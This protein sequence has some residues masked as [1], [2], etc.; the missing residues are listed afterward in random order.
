M[1]AFALCLHVLAAA[2]W[3]GGQLLLA[4]VV[5]PRAWRQGAPELVLTHEHGLGRIALGALAV[6]VAS[7]LWMAHV[8]VPEVTRWWRLDGPM[9]TAVAWKIG[10]LVLS[11]ALAL[12]TR[13][14]LLPRL[15][16]DR[17][18]GLAGWVAANTLLAV[19][20]VVLGVSFRWGGIGLR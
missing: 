8:L 12:H 19:A 2:I 4:L 10:L 5:L 1:Y 6:L 11:V 3:A 14:V 7:G 16:A 18:R 9:A 15:R 13:Q 17:L 20:M